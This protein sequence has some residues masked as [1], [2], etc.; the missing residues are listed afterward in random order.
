M[1][2]FRPCLKMK[3]IITLPSLLITKITIVCCGY[4]VFMILGTL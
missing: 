4:L 1:L 2:T 3:G